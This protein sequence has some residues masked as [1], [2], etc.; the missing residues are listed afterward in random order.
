MNLMVL[1]EL[2][3]PKKKK[4]SDKIHDWET[5][6]AVYRKD[7]FEDYFEVIEFLNTRKRKN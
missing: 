3:P 1:T 7:K 4:N 2:L 5:K 6:T